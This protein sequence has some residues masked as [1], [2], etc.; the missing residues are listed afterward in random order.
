MNGN[1]PDPPDHAV[2]AQRTGRVDAGL[3]VQ[4]GFLGDQLC[5]EQPVDLVPC[6]GHLRSDGVAEDLADGG[7]M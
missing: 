6:R 1:G 2:G 5:G 4:A 3:L 7:D